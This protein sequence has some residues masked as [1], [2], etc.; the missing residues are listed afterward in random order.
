VYGVIPAAAGAEA[1]ELTGVD[2][3]HVEAIAES[4]LVAL[5]SR[6]EHDTLSARDIR[7]HWRVL[8]QA[9]ERT[10]VLPMRFGTVLE[11]EAAV[12]ESLLQPNADH[13]NQLL[14]DMEGLVQLNVKARY[15][16]EPLLREIVRGSPAVAKARRRLAQ[17]SGGG[18][19]ADQLALGQLVESEIGRLRVADTD[20]A[21][22][23][24]A[25]FAVEMREEQVDHPAVFSLAC[26]VERRREPELSTG[27]AA[28]REALGERVEIR[29]VGPL[30]PFSFA[31]SDLTPGSGSW[32]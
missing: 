26:L 5:T 31:E 17:R 29:Y 23:I 27:V 4:G 9:F 20:V 12:R 24:L 30:P 28:V 8:E 3:E 19:P 22:E 16:E 6:L 18:A 13:L 10:T 2:G 25:P 7:A 1:S 11:D 15:V 32:A 21:V 14:A